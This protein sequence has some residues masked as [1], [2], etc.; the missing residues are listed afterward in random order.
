MQLR[1]Q[2][3]IITDPHWLVALRRAMLAHIP[4]RPTLR[5][6]QSVAQHRGRLTPPGRAYQFPRDISFSARTSSA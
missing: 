2:R 6:P 3:G 5:Q 1:A 4:A